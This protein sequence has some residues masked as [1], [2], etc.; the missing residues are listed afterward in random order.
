[1]NRF[2][3]LVPALIIG[4]ASLVWA[5]PGCG[6]GGA[7]GGMGAGSSTGSGGT[8]EITATCQVQSYTLR[9]EGHC[10]FM[11]R[12]DGEGT[13][14]GHVQIQC[15]GK[16]VNEEALCSGT[17]RPSSTEKVEFEIAEIGRDVVRNVCDTWSSDRSD[18]CQANFEADK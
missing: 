3:V 4:T 1:M 15:C 16:I 13:L 11:N 6:K 10:T 17:V 2:G 9:T 7:G 8:P 18:H 5:L 12:G 14:C